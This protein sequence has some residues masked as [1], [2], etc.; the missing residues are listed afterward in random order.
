MRLQKIPT[1]KVGPIT[2]KRRR[3]AGGSG[4][5]VRHHRGPGGAGRQAAENSGNLLAQVPDPA[6]ES[7]C[8]LPG[9]GWHRPRPP[10]RV[11]CR[12]AC[13]R[14]R[15]VVL[16]QTGLTALRRNRPGLCCSPNKR[17]APGPA[18]PVGRLTR[19][20]SRLRLERPSCGVAVRLGT[21][22]RRSHGRN[23]Y[24]DR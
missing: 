16:A 19:G 8:G 1:S 20:S 21:D 11:A 18:P 23:C 3:L 15:H 9:A 12:A 5:P 4:L 10:R 14:S 24:L 2:R 17:Q 13:R 6:A 7:A 22:C